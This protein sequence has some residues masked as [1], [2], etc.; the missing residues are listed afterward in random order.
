MIEKTTGNPFKFV[1]QMNLVSITG[2]K[3]SNLPEML[4]YLKS[5]PA[6][7]VY[8]HTHLFLKQ[9]HYLS[10]E[11][12]N[13][14]AW[15]ITYVLQERRLGEQLLA[16]DTVRFNTL[17]ALAAKIIQVFEH[18]LNNNSVARTA[19]E[20]EEFYF[21]KSQSFFIDTPYTVSTL[22]EFSD[23]VQRVSIHSLY[24]HM[25]EARIRLE[26]G[27]NDFSK[28]LSEELGEIDL[29]KA[30]ARFDP[31][32]HTLEDLR[33]KIVN[34]CRNRLLTVKESVRVA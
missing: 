22:S 23:A 8:H 14:F 7:V 21:L 17:A 9:H 29:A 31:Y 6:S 16:I 4:A 34:L 5:A 32:T 11:P 26:K 20:G 24:H 33:R 15:W 27:A 3:A 13:D 10:P 19:P 18:H 2:A 1:T 30:I 28:W 12:P 25:F